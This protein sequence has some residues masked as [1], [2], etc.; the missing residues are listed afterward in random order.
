[1]EAPNPAFK[2][3]WFG[4]Y[5]LLRLLG[6]GGMAE[7][8]LGRTTGAHDF[9]KLVVVKRI[10]ARLRD[11]P[12]FVEMFV[13]E[14]KRVVLLQHANIVQVLSLQEYEG[15]SFIVMEY[16]HGKNMLEVLRAALKDHVGLP[17][18]F[19]IHC[20]TE[21]LKGL[22]YAHDA[23]GPDGQQLNLIHRDIT[24]ENVFISFDGEVK[25]GDFG[26]AHSAGAVEKKELRGKMGYIA[27]ETVEDV[28]LDQRSDIFSA[29]VVLWEVLA[30]RRLFTGKSAADVLLQV[31]ERVPA[32]PSHFN[33][34]VPPDL[35]RIVA[36]ALEKKRK[37][38]YQSAQELE[39]ALSDFL[40]ARR[41]RWT[42]RRIADVMAA[43][44]A[45]DA[46]MSEFPKT[47]PPVASPAPQM[48]DPIDFSDAL[49]DSMVKSLG[50]AV[51]SEFS[52]LS[53][54]PEQSAG[55]WAP[56]MDSHIFE[57]PPGGS[58][59]APT[60]PFSGSDA[61]DEFDEP[62]MAERILLYS[63]GD[64][65][66]APL[67]IDK[68][69][70]KVAAAPG[71]VEALSVLGYA[72]VPAAA[73]GPL[74]YWD[75]LGGM[76]ELPDEADSEGRFFAMSATRLLFEVSIRRMTG[77]LLIEDGSGERHR[78]LLLRDGMPLYIYSDD[79]HEG[80]LPMLHHHQLVDL[81]SLFRALTRSLRDRRPLDD[82]LAE[83]LRQL[84]EGDAL[85]KT[86]S[87]LTGLLMRR[88]YPIFHWVDGGYR[89][90][91]QLLAPS[92]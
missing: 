80:A 75:V 37:L 38:R 67:S 70:Q 54:L 58:G 56:P 76:P 30:Q 17:I 35:D 61:D 47:P 8:Y 69:I 42:R 25:L 53:E 50:D 48:P 64:S 41:L 18:D 15:W 23:R 49:A 46:K 2:P 55:G 39:E 60:S 10:L 78:L 28:A 62:T 3:H 43:R 34:K 66:P 81:N 92:P 32:P 88:L 65:I 26:V 1:M 7:V 52:E 73:L 71:S 87:N 22:G 74:L 21:M 16:V 51:D 4:A 9:R 90:Y 89:A 33:P 24:P 11:Q 72:Q 20:L 59:G 63:S 45:D 91:T 29:G 84:G 82:A 14:A 44:H 85:A 83:S 5:E 68:L 57:L 79:G 40:Y 13:A 36:K 12:R 19:G 6:V 27:P 86:H 31:R 77:S